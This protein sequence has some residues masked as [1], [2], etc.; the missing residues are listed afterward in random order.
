MK[1]HFVQR[2]LSLILVFGLLP[3]VA[4]GEA[5]PVTNFRGLLDVCEEAASQPPFVY[6]E[7]RDNASLSARA[8]LILGDVIDTWKDSKGPLLIEAEVLS[9]N[10]ESNEIWNAR[11][12]A[13]EDFLKSRGI[14][15]RAFWS[16]I[17]RT[18]RYPFPEDEDVLNRRVFVYV[19]SALPACGKRARMGAIDWLTKHCT[20]ATT[21]SVPAECAA[22]LDWLRNS[23]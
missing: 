23:P 3:S 15:E 7:R 2:G 1:A 5:S 21:G 10:H 17:R 20:P 9:A 8:K 14:P 19:P 12:S 4:F 18:S 22:T 11:I 16:R 13:V 6:F